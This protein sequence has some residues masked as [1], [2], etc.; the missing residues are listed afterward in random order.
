MVFQR[1]RHTVLFLLPTLLVSLVSFLPP[2]FAQDKKTKPPE[3]DGEVR[4]GRENAAENDKSVKLITDAALLD[5]VNRIG[6]EL[7][8]VAN[9][10]E[11]PALWG[12]STLKK[13]DYVFKVVD[14][15]DVNAYS[16]PGG[17]IYVNKGLLD[18]CRS[19][20][21][22]AGVL[23]H[24]IAHAAHHHMMK[25]IREQKKMQPGMLLLLAVG[26]AAKANGQDLINLFNAGQFYMVAKLNTYGI[27]AEK[28]ADHTGMQY[29][30]KT[31]FNPV[32]L[33]TFME[34]LARDEMRGPQRDL[35]IFRTHPPS[36][37]RAV[38]MQGQ[39]ESMNIP[40]NRRAVDPTISA[41]VTNSTQNGV[42]LAEVKMGKI[43]VA[44]LAAGEGLSAEDRAKKLSL[45]LNQ[46]FDAGLQMF[47]VRLNVDK[48]RILARGQTL[49][50][51]SQADA[52]AQK[53]TVPE[54]AQVTLDAIKNLL[55]QDQFNK[56]QIPSPPKK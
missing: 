14:D 40:I 8:A 29:L 27:E 23:A 54:M 44:K 50:N 46:L 15:K 22:L 11:V 12:S 34:R 45:S 33:L 9:T 28:D 55:W 32:G 1:S 49:I 56:L 25:L 31:K 7:A 21:E 13:F 2:V 4:L 10:T 37:D 53:T 26:L 41:T 6:Q 47:E 19:D 52:D 36:P 39:L 48:T 3:E 18:Y 51:F 43:V 42:S 5:R 35:G 17:F 30:V 38:A 20:D 16:L 24:E